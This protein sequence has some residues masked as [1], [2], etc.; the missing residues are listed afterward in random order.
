MSQLTLTP[1]EDQIVLDAL[2]SKGAT[3]TA[4]FGS[5]DPA[6]EVL[7]AKVQSQLPT[8]TLVVKE[9]PAEE[10][11]AEAICLICN[12]SCCICTKEEVS[13]KSFAKKV[14]EEVPVKES[15]E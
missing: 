1:Q 2:R 7:I 12:S 10:T 15:K 11:V 9:A 3:Y 13:K 5:M 6:L 8:E 4:M 14:V